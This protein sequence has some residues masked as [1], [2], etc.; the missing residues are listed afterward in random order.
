MGIIEQGLMG[1]GGGY[2]V[3]RKIPTSP[4]TSPVLN[5]IISRYPLPFPHF[6]FKLKTLHHTSVFFGKII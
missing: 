3:F 5:G 2:F 1:I 6:L 4:F